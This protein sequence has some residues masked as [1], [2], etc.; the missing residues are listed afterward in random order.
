MIAGHYNFYVQRGADFSRLF[1]K[2]VDGVAV[3]LTGLKVRAQF[4]SLAGV[5]GTTTTSTLLLELTDGN[6]IAITSA[7]AGEI[8]LTLTNAQ[9]LVLCPTNVKTR[10]AYGIELYYD[11]ASPEVVTP[12]LQGTVTVVPE[13]VR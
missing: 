3:N 6:G 2:L 9:T 8:T 11:G 13:T 10:L 5:T 4:R 7:V 12:F 1:R